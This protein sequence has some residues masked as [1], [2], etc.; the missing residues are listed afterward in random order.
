MFQEFSVKVWLDDEQRKIVERHAKR[1]IA[2][3]LQTENTSEWGIDD[4]LKALLFYA[5]DVERAVQGAR[6]T[7]R[8]NVRQ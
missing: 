2:T 8:T 1:M 5:I 3:I 6:Q 4:S 7:Q